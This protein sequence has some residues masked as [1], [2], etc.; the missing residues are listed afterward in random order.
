MPKARA[1]RAERQA[2]GGG[3]HTAN[4]KT[5]TAAHETAIARQNPWGARS[6]ILKTAGAEGEGKRDGDPPFCDSKKRADAPGKN[7]SVRR[8]SHHL[9]RMDAPPRVGLREGGTQSTL[10]VPSRKARTRR[11]A[12][13][14]ASGGLTF[15]VSG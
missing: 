4:R 6:A 15:E 2:T 9:W 14:R 13:L 8:M 7:A 10:R 11:A 3:R 1:G 5:H 12:R